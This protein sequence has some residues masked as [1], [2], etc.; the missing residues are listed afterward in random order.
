MASVTWTWS[1]RIE[2][3]AREVG[4][5][6]MLLDD[7]RAKERAIKAKGTPQDDRTK[8]DLEALRRDRSIA[9]RQAYQRRKQLGALIEDGRNAEPDKR[10]SQAQIAAVKDLGDALKARGC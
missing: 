5:T 4:L 1:P 6:V 7:V 2:S 3:L 9:H 10:M 8:A